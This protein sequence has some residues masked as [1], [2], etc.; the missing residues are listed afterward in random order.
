MSVQSLLN[1]TLTVSRRILVDD[2]SG[3]SEQV[4]VEIGTVRAQVNQP[5]DLEQ[6]RGAIAGNTNTHDVHMLPT[7]DVRV[8]DR[9]TGDGQLLE[10]LAT[11]SPSRKVYLKAIC[12]LRQVEGSANG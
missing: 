12:E 1:R 9:L 5:T 11:K 10:V 3:G 7:S 6:I 2:G 8:G 4:W